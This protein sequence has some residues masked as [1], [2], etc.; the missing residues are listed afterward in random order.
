MSSVF[1]IF[2]PEDCDFYYDGDRIGHITAN[3]V[4]AFR[5]EVERKGTYRVRFINSRYKSVLIMNLT[6]GVDE[7]QDVDLDFTAVNAPVIKAEEERRCAEEERR[8][9]AEEAERRRIAEEKRMREAEEAER[10]RRLEAE[11]RRAEEAERERMVEEQRKAREAERKAF[12]EAE[13]KRK[14]EEARRRAAEEAE[15]AE[16]RRIAAE[17]ER[18]RLLEEAERKRRYE[19]A[20]RKRRCE[21]A[22][23]KAEEEARR[24]R[25]RKEQLRKA[26]E[27]EKCRYLRDD[28]KKASA[29]DRVIMGHEFVD[30]GLSVYWATCNVG[31]ECP[32]EYGDSF[33]WGETSI[34]S[35]YTED[36]SKTMYTVIDQSDVLG[37]PQYDAARANWGDNWR[38]PTEWEVEELIEKCIWDWVIIGGRMG[39]RVKSKINGN[40]IFIPAMEEEFESVYWTG[41]I[42]SIFDDEDEIRAMVLVFYKGGGE[43]EVDWVR[44]YEPALVRPVYDRPKEIRPSI[45]QQLFGFIKALLPESL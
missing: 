45:L 8:K 42:P 6:I 25:E 15:A 36:N 4:K 31:A 38:L 5:F 12:E 39:Y 33:A 44:R 43:L 35:V 10:K 40:S 1:K 24:E 2:S 11:R 27:H 13:R 37:N 17:A 21:E 18:K 20:E 28:F 7:E 26:F 29:E 41:S 3:S 16:K 34:K 23:R 9:A 30:L 19:E 32:I 22:K 14:A